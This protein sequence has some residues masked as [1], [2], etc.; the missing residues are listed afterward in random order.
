M[1]VFCVLLVSLISY[2]GAAGLNRIRQVDHG[3]TECSRLATN[4]PSLL[5]IGRC[6]RWNVAASLAV[7]FGASL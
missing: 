3:P 2:K 1:L 5:V 4:L 7:W 6:S